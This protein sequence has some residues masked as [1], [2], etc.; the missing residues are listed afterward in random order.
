MFLEKIIIVWP[1]V[2]G[3][4]IGAILLGLIL[5]ITFTILRGKNMQKA[6]LFAKEKQY[7][8]SI[9][10]LNKLTRSKIISKWELSEVYMI[11]AAIYL[12][13]SEEEQFKNSIAKVTYKKYLTLKSFWEALYY[14]EIEDKENYE[15]SKEN[16]TKYF[17]LN[18]KMRNENQGSLNTYFLVLSLL[19]EKEKIEKREE[20]RNLCQTF[21]DTKI[22]LKEYLSKL[23]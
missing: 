1:A 9:E 13:M 15:N 17:N 20:L 7:S 5:G 16:I 21:S 12:I 22:L 18:C 3:S 6:I 14:L 8:A 11:L 4:I 2:Y 19:E 23:F 10:I